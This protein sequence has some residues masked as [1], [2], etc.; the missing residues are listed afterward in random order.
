MKLPCVVVTMLLCSLANSVSL[1]HDSQ[2]G[3]C[4]NNQILLPNFTCGCDVHKFMF[5]NNSNY[6]EHCPPPG[7]WFAPNSSCL[8]CAR[9]LVVNSTTGNCICPPSHPHLAPNLTCVHCPHPKFWNQ[10]AS[11]CQSCGPNQHWN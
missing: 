4:V 6:C 9:S 5:L 7:Q 3:L 2:N 1:S 10:T 8:V 11:Q